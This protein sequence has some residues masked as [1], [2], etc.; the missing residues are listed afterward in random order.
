[1][2]GRPATGWDADGGGVTVDGL[3]SGVPGT[4]LFNVGDLRCPDAAFSGSAEC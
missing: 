3:A 4:G 1:M 2:A